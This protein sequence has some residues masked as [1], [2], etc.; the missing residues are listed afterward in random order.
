MQTIGRAAKSVG[1]SR[2]TLL[3]YDRIG[4]L[5]P[6]GRSP[7]GYRVYSDA[8]MRR[9]EKIVFFRRTG[10]SLEEIARIL[11]A[12]ESKLGSIMKRRLA[13]L[14]D[15]IQVLRE[16]QQVVLKLLRHDVRPPWIRGMNK[17]K[18][19]ALLR[20]VGLDDQRMWE[21]H[22]RFEE[23]TPRGHHDFLSALGIDE[24]E[25]AAIRKWAG[26]GQSGE[27]L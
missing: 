20:A 17:K 2:S 26:G 23:M 12:S 18:W 19:V 15:Q 24:S 14:T 25:I 5:I 22:V 11:E 9:L 8:D 6:S 27:T 21:W 4:L 3:Y 10:A 7:A 16:Q 1:L 13:E